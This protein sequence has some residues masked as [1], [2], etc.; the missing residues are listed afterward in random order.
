MGDGKVALIL[1]VMG[2]A[3]SARVVNQTRER[4]RLESSEKGE[5][6]N[7]PTSRPCSF[8]EL[9]K[10]GAWPFRFPW[11]PDWKNSNVSDIEKSGEQEVVQY[12][13]EIMPLICLGPKCSS[14]I[15]AS[16]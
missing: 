3:Q 11:W 12:R 15:R 6:E 1:D 9:E 8:L 4:A 2:L 16:D 5:M 14:G 10:R 7:Q 13:G